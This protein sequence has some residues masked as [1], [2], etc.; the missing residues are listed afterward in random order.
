AFEVDPGAAEMRGD[1]LGEIERRRAPHVIRQIAIHLLPERGIVLGFGVS[2]LELEDDRHQRLGNEAAAVD[3][4]VSALVRPGAE[5]VGFVLD[6]HARLA[7]RGVSSASRAARMKAR[8]LS[9]S[10][11]P[12]ARSTPDDTSTA[13]ARVIRSASAT[14]PG[15]SPPDSM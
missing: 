12:G 14:L 15:S 1:A 2:L 11:T 10:F 9:G 6:G 13:G 5:R 7:T 3:A 4:E 8:I